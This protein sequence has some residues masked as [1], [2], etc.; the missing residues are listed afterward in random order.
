MLLRKELLNTIWEPS[1]KKAARS[2]LKAQAALWRK[3]WTEQTSFA[4][5][6]INLK[7]KFENLSCDGGKFI[8]ITN[9]NLPKVPYLQLKQNP[10]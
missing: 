6:Q 9:N 5:I 1:T 8:F 2:R 7:I 10:K 4:F 3:R